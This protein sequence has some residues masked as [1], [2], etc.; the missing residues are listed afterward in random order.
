VASFANHPNPHWSEQQ[1]LLKPVDDGV[2][3]PTEQVQPWIYERGS[4]A[5]QRRPF[6]K[7]RHNYAS[8]VGEQLHAFPDSTQADFAAIVE[9]EEGVNVEQSLQ[10]MSTELR[11]RQD[12]YEG[13]RL[14]AIE[15]DAQDLPLSPDWAASVEDVTASKASSALYRM[16]VKDIEARSR[17]IRRWNRQI[18][19]QR[20][21]GERGGFN[22]ARHQPPLESDRA[23][24]SPSLRAGSSGA[25]SSCL[26]PRARSRRIRRMNQLAAHLRHQFESIHG[27]QYVSDT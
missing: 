15:A 8:D 11:K 21:F 10:E 27:A 20:P 3:Y 4:V 6:E 22:Y 13:A 26:S 18:A 7:S 25:V 5:M 9:E 19:R 2:Q 12:L 16:T 23:L 24:P 1:G 14:I 17:R